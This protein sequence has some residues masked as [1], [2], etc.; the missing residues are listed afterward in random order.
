MFSDTTS[1]ASLIGETATTL[2]EILK[3]SIGCCSLKMSRRFRQ[4]LVQNIALIESSALIFFNL[5][6]HFV[7]RKSWDMTRVA[8]ACARLSQLWKTAIVATEILM[9]LIGCLSLRKSRRFNDEIGKATCMFESSALT[10][11]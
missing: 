11:F 4:G 3:G 7:K 5:F 2:F 6:L 1:I 8:T 10:F 9:E